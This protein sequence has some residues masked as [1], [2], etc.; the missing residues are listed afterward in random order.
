MWLWMPGETAYMYD[1]HK[2]SVLKRVRIE[3]KRA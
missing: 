3:P 2:F 1:L